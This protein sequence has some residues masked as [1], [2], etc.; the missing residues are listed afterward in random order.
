[1][2][3]P[4]KIDLKVG[5]TYTLRL[6]GLGAAGYLW[7]YDIAWDSNLIDI[8]QTT[9]K[10]SEFPAVGSSMDQVFILRGLAT[11][12]LTIRFMQRRPWEKNQP[13]VAEHTL[14]V[15]IKA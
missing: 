4:A 10:S 6:P 14:E 11:G 3:L 13:P 9:A 1:M 15:D 2:E 12:H 8:S 5:E 7:T